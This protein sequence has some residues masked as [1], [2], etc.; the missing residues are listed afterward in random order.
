MKKDKIPDSD[1]IEELARFW[2]THDLT[3]YEEEMEVV[4]DLVI[5]RK[6][7]SCV[8]VVVLDPDLAEVF[9]DAASVNE[10]LRE[11]LHQKGR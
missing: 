2:D 5:E 8:K 3:D 4:T 10:A 9:P 11:F 6:P 7:E 1:S